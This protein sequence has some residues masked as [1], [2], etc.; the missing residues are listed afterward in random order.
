MATALNP[1]EIFERAASEGDRRLGQ[2]LLELIATAFIAG[3]TIVFG[4]VALGV[5]E[6]LARPALGDLSKLLAALAFGVGVVF[7]VVGRAELFSENFFDPIA[8]GFR[9]SDRHFGRKLFRLWLLSL[10]LN[11]VGGAL[12]ILVVSV[13]GTLPSGA[14]DALNRLAE[15]IA[16]RHWLPTF[17]RAII[18]GALVALL[19]FLVIASR[20]TTGRIIMAYA[21]GVLLALGPFDHVIVSMLHVGFGLASTANVQLFHV[22]EVGLIAL[23]GNLIGGVGL[24]TLSHVAQAK[25]AERK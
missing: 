8:A 17:T 11:L 3:F 7:L 5:V 15:E 19:S 2:S 10:L 21:V 20:D 22:A 9:G 25:A 4:I 18:G 16:H 23:A 1:A 24:V 13:G 14:S 12:L 6:G